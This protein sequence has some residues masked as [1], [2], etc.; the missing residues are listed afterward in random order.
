[1]VKNGLIQAYSDNGPK[2]FK[3][4]SKNLKKG[5]DKPNDIWYY[6]QRRQRRGDLERM[7]PA[8]LEND[9]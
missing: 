9:T 3:K 7:T 5:V 1:V 8:N 2:R 4:S 6:V